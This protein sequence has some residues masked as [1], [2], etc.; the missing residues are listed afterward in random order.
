MVIIHRCCKEFT[1]TQTFLEMD[2]VEL[3]GSFTVFIGEFF[4]FL[5]KELFQFIGRSHCFCTWFFSRPLP[6]KL[7][8]DTKTDGV[9]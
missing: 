2:I 4:S 9:T 1:Y 6:V 8:L 3:F 5:S 7:Y